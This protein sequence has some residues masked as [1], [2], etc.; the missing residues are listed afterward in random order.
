M[1]EPN[2]KPPADKKRQ[3]IAASMGVGIVL[4]IAL[5]VAFDNIGLG[6][7]LGILIGGIGAAWRRGRFR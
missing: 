5:G 6:L 1:N 4:G 2:L 7:A 3:Q